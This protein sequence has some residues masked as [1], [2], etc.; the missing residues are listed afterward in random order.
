MWTIYC[1]RKQNLSGRQK[2]NGK[3]GWRPEVREIDEKRP[4]MGRDA[5]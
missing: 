2:M 4:K 5:S 3:I 1:Q